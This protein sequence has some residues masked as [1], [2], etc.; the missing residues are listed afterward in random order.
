M[1]GPSTDSATA[2]SSAALWLA[3][4]NAMRNS[5][6]AIRSAPWRLASSM[7]RNAFVRFS[8]LSVLDCTWAMAILLMI[9]LSAWIIFASHA[10]QVGYQRQSTER[11]VLLERFLSS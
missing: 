1:N 5:G 3:G 11:A 2:V 8:F 7:R 10:I 6:K 4:E 9:Y